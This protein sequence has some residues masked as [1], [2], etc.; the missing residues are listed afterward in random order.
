MPNV[1]EMIKRKIR[2]GMRQRNFPA[3]VSSAS[4]RTQSGTRLEAVKR[5]A[6]GVGI[7]V[8]QMVCT[9]ARTKAEGR[10]A[11]VEEIDRRRPDPKQ[12]E[13]E[14]NKRKHLQSRPAHGNVPPH[15]RRQTSKGQLGR[16]KPSM[17]TQQPSAVVHSENLASNGPAPESSRNLSDLPPDDG[18]Q[19]IEAQ[20]PRENAIPIGTQPPERI[21][22]QGSENG[23][24][25]DFPSP[26]MLPRAMSERLQRVRNHRAHREWLQDKLQRL[27]AKRHQKRLQL[28]ELGR[29]QFAHAADVNF[30]SSLEA[31]VAGRGKDS[32]V[33]DRYRHLGL[34]I[35]KIR[36][37]MDE[38]DAEVFRSSASLVDF[39]IEKHEDELVPG[40]ILLGRFAESDGYEYSSSEGSSVRRG[41]ANTQRAKEPL[42]PGESEQFNRSDAGALSCSSSEHQAHNM[43]RDHSKPAPDSQRPSV[44]KQQ[45]QL[46]TELPG[47]PES[48]GRD[49]PVSD[50]EPEVQERHHTRIPDQPDPELSPLLDDEEFNQSANGQQFRERQLQ[51]ARARSRAR[52]RLQDEHGRFD[53]FWKTY[54][55]YKREFERKREAGEVNDSVSVL[56]RA[57]LQEG[58]YHTQDLI[59]AEKDYGKAAWD[60]KDLKVEILSPNLTSVFPSNDE[61]DQEELDREIEDI[62]RGLNRG[63]I[64]EWIE[65]DWQY[66]RPSTF[67]DPDAEP[68]L[69][70]DPGPAQDAGEGLPALPEVPYG[71][72]EDAWALHRRRVHID[73]WGKWARGDWQAMLQEWPTM[74]STREGVPISPPTGSPKPDPIRLQTDGDGNSDDEIDNQ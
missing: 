5:L 60:A 23:D 25:V 32:P 15:K 37:K 9:R 47:R 17:A 49:D 65:E 72:C 3:I 36:E 64:A 48:H 50:S 63:L 27:E 24:I 54:N 45:S 4:P 34:L 29:G 73:L 61:L 31:S 6:R 18:L 53:Q 71:L 10:E 21:G 13:R 11:E 56:D 62:E 66:G 42:L 58:Q 41:S 33:R 67:D 20:T 74:T 40:E 16:R 43:Q 52:E 7:L 22:Q 46:T 14:V 26:S 51:A 59:K 12:I 39:L 44:P 55:D 19:N 1:C 8:L 35:K 57:F 30:E 68:L 69:K 28:E 38:V 70:P 2:Q